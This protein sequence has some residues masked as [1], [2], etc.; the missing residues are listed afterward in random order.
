MRLIIETW[1]Y[2]WLDAVYMGLP[3]NKQTVLINP[4]MQYRIFE[5]L[6]SKS[7]MA[8]F[9]DSKRCARVTLCFGCS[10]NGY[11]DF[12]FYARPQRVGRRRLQDEMRIISIFGFGAPYIRDFTVVCKSVLDYSLR[13]LYTQGKCGSIFHI[14]CLVRLMQIIYPYFLIPSPNCVNKSF[15]W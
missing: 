15:L 12:P 3:Y 13:I 4:V 1:R 7:A 8:Y 2:V 11:T 5:Q 6:F 14:L 9:I 10:S